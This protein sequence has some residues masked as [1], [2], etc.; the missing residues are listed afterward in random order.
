MARLQN[1]RLSKLAKDHAQLRDILITHEMQRLVRP[2]IPVGPHMP[3]GHHLAQII[4]P[5]YAPSDFD[6]VAGSSFTAQYDPMLDFLDNEFLFDTSFPL[7]WPNGQ[8]H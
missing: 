8:S 5:P 1:T 2:T 6:G 3:V 7:L 4:T